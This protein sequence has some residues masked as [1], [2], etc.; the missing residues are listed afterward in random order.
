MSAHDI[1]R[2]LHRPR[3]H[4][5]GVRMQQGRLLLDS[6]FNEST[7]LHEED[8]RRTLIDLFGP[9]ASPNQ[10]F[11]IGNA[12]TGS[13]PDQV[14][15]L[16]VGDP[17]PIQT[18]S[19]NGVAVFVRA[20]AVRQGSYYVGGQRVDLE[21]P[22]HIAFQS[23]FLQFGSQNSNPLD[24]GDSFQQFYYLHCWEQAVSSTEDEEFR[25]AAL[26]GEDTSVRVRRMRRVEILPLAAPA[27]PRR[28]WRRLQRN[29]ALD[30][31]VLDANTGEAR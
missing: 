11:S 2:Y 23:D 29:L 4:S 6:D 10:G 7:A 20:V 17:V 14:A 31:A 30:N 1:T 24:A 8:R 9:A 5:V 26:G 21:L 25:E 27:S 15:F 12:F 19:V 13:P 3:R 16:G 28:A 22:E 18:V